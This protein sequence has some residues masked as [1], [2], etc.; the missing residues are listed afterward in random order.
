MSVLIYYYVKSMTS[1]S[2]VRGIRPSPVC[3]SFA[4]RANGWYRGACRRG[5]FLARFASSPASYCSTSSGSAGRIMHAG[6]HTRRWLSGSSGG[7]VPHFFLRLPGSPLSGSPPLSPSDSDGSTS[8]VVSLAFEDLGSLQK[9]GAQAAQVQLRD[10]TPGCCPWRR[11]SVSRGS[12][13]PTLVDRRL[14]FRLCRVC[15]TGSQTRPGAVLQMNRGSLWPIP[16][17]SAAARGGR[18]WAI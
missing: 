15:P 11:A 14:L 17:K 4:G 9:R 1:F 3:A 18:C 8:Y 13:R 10:D 16:M 12:S 7:P 5:D 2:C 6:I